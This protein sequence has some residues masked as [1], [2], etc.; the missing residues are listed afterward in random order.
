MSKI[1]RMDKRKGEKI[2]VYELKQGKFG[3]Y[4][5]DS[6][7]KINLS[8]RSVLDLLN[9]YAETYK[10]QTQNKVF[11]KADSQGHCSFECVKCI[12]SG[13]V[14]GLIQFKDLWNNQTK[15]EEKK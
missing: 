12:Y 15:K 5:Y 3:Y 7:D 9:K 6:V 8:L 11:C 2:M 13:G 14:N 4:F 1:S 10:V